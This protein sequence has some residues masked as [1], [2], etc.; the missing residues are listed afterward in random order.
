MSTWWDRVKYDP[1]AALSDGVATV[2]ETV[3]SSE[4]GAWL[5]ESASTVAAT[6]STRRGR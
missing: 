4:T 1:L 2:T 6:A 5:L 3:N